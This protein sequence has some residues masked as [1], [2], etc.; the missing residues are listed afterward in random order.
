[1]ITSRAPASQDGESDHQ[2]EEGNE[3]EARGDGAEGGQEEEQE[4]EATDESQEQAAEPEG[5]ADSEGRAATDSRE[6]TATN[7]KH[8]VL[9]FC[10][11]CKPSA[12]VSLMSQKSRIVILGLEKSGKK[13]LLEGKGFSP[14]SMDRTEPLL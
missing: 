3:E 10:T 1:M 8:I 6:R 2:E 14:R 5:G 4:A 9:V 7:A 13:T 12:I 11:K